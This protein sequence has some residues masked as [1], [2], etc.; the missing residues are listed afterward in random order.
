LSGAFSTLTGCLFE[1]SLPDP[2]ACDAQLPSASPI[3]VS[4]GPIHALDTSQFS[5]L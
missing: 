4:G 2:A 3:Q 5:R 1:P